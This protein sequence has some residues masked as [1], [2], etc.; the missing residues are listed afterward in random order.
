MTAPIEQPPDRFALPADLRR[1]AGRQLE[2]ILTRALRGK[3]PREVEK[4]IVRETVTLALDRAAQIGFVWARRQDAGAG[5]VELCYDDP[6]FG[7][8]G[9]SEPPT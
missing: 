4:V 8:L 6:E 9:S 7:L 2:K 1:Q 5:R 3:V